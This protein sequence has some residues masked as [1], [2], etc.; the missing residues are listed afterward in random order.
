MGI[1]IF[2]L[3]VIAFGFSTVMWGIAGIFAFWIAVAILIGLVTV[4]V[5]TADYVAM[6]SGKGKACLHGRIDAKYPNLRRRTATALRWAFLATL[7]VMFAVALL[8]ELY[9]WV[10]E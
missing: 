7:G 10:A 2:L 6:W 3:A 5:L 1:I 8:V 4:L 9:Q